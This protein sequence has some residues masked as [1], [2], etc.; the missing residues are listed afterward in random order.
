[1][2]ELR[3]SP[4]PA[5]QASL[6][7]LE[8]GPPRV[9]APA[10][11]FL[12]SSILLINRFSAA[13]SS[14]CG[15]RRGGR[16]PEKTKSV[17]SVSTLMPRMGLTGMPAKT[18]ALHAGEDGSLTCRRRRQPYMRGIFLSRPLYLLFIIRQRGGRKVRQAV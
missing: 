8:Q 3:S 7:K 16:M 1:M 15:S 11:F 6:A 17:S 9:H 5:F 2:L 4:V 10:P 14:S 13:S 18:A 12:Y